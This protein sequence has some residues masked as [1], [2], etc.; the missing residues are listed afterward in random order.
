MKNFGWNSIIHFDREQEQNKH[1]QTG[2]FGQVFNKNDQPVP[3][4]KVS[5]INAQNMQILNSS[6]DENG[7]FY[8]QAINTDKL[9]NFAIKAIGPDGSED[10]KVEFKKSFAEQVSDE[11]QSFLQ[12]HATLK[13]AQFS[14]DFYQKNRDLFTKIRIEPVDR[15][16]AEP[17]YKKYLQTA[18]SLLEVL[19]IIKPYRLDG[20]KIIFPGGANSINAQDGALIV[21]DGQKMGT[22]AS[23][24]NSLSPHDVETIN[25]STSPVEI[26]RYT[27]LN[28]VGLIEIWTKRGE[29]TEQVELLPA[30]NIFDGDYRIPRDF[31]LIKSEKPQQQP[32]TMFWSPAVKM[33]PNGRS[34]FEVNAG[35]VLGKFIIQADLI[36][37]NGQMTKVHKTI[38]VIR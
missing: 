17:A 9:D 4:A 3:N 23:V 6:T 30:E 26:Q 14:S 28:S 36:D 21:I 12:S 18:T 38:E 27:G 32:T 11:V 19:K 24:L 35:P 20:D 22:S 31:W 16:A 10:L 34:E 37:S 15:E 7:E 25:V 1:Q 33:N 2:T 5:F 29:R 13:Q 8:Q